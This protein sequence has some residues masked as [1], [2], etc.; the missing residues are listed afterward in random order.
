MATNFQERRKLRLQREKFSKARLAEKQYGR[1][2]RAVAREVGNIVQGFTHENFQQDVT[3]MMAALHDYARILSPWARSVAQRMLAEVSIRNERA[4]F[5]HAD[6]MGVSL[7][8]EIQQ[9]PVGVAMRQSLA[10]QVDLITSLPRGAANRV[11]HLTIEGI[12]KGLRPE[13]LAKEILRTGNVTES[14]A[15]TIARTEVGRTATALTE[16]RATYVGSEGYIWRTAGDSDVRRSH[17]RMEGK[18]VPW[19]SPPELDGMT[20]H[21]GALPNCRC[22][23]EPVLPAE[24]Q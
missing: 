1:Q 9:A 15:M 11:H 16:A 13:T 20:G 21:A 7:R 14:R 5:Q 17:K 10:E 22:Y 2:L 18:F 24:I 23:P 4:W 12:T 19:N 3:Q 8:K 6:Q